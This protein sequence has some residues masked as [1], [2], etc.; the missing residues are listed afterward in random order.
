MQNLSLLQLLKILSSAQGASEEESRA[1]TNPP[2]EPTTPE[3][4]T[5]NENTS[6]RAGTPDRAAENR[7]ADSP[8]RA[9]EIFSARHEQ[10]V[11]R[12]RNSHNGVR[13]DGD[14]GPPR[15]P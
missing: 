2:S 4:K 14:G 5:E 10:A 9:Y 15:G 11:R 6:P 8:A 13:D 1:Q 7:S 3:N 12:A